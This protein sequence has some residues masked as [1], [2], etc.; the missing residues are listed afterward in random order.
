MSDEAC[1]C[2]E[3]TTDQTTERTATPDGGFDRWLD[4]RPVTTAPLPPDAS[5]LWGRF[6]RQSSIETLD[7][8]VA[9][10][11]AA[12]GGGPIA[13]EDLCHAGEETPHRARTADATHHFRCFFD[14]V[15]LA[16]LA[17][18]PVEIRTASP[19]GTPVE[20]RA[21]PDGGVDAAPGAAMSFGIAADVDPLPDG[22]GAP[23]D[24]YRAM[25]PYVKAFPSRERY[26]GW[27]AA[28]DAA[29]VGMPLAAGMPIAT[30][31]ADGA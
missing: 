5:R 14:G 10:T 16:H 18:E 20:V 21:S 8:V 26:E 31:L 3:P 2:C 13:V 19:A 23:D 6:Y 1:D 29:T 24:L 27:A 15:A 22:D 17:D 7:D 9:A 25:C 11:R 4:E 28:V 12:A 30:A